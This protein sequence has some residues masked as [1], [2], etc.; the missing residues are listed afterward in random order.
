[1]QTTPNF[2]IPYPESSDTISF[3]TDLGNVAIGA[4]Y[5]LNVIQNQVNA[6]ASA[7]AEIAQDAVAD[8]FAAGTQTNISVTYN[9]GAG[10]ISL[11]VPDMTA[12]PATPSTRGILYGVSDNNVVGVGKGSLSSVTGVN[13]TALG[14]NAGLN[15]VDGTN[16]MLLGYNAQPTS[17]SA[18][19]QITL[20]NSSITTLRCQATAITSLSDARDK[21]LVSDIPFGLQFINVLRPVQF[22]WNTRDGARYNEPDIGFIAQDV[23]AAEDAFRAH[24]I[25]KLTERDNPDRLEVTQGRLIPILVKAIQELT[26]RVADL[27]SELDFRRMSSLV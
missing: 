10:S 16:S 25:L 24:D 9:D 23:V 3:F 12:S 27:E 14:V 26:E 7:V 11:S 22:V 5:A 1:M 21:N 17:A 15:L 19:N 20:G 4:D 18:S 13:N 2:N 6:N 8:A